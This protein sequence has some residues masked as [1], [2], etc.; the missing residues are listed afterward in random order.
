MDT[1]ARQPPMLAWAIAPNSSHLA[2]ALEGVTKAASKR[3]MLLVLY[4]RLSPSVLPSTSG[5]PLPSP[6]HTL[7]LGEPF[8]TVTC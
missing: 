2:P 1:L 7:A 8:S 3:Y 4:L 5:I 6:D